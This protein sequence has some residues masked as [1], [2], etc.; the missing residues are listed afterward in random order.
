MIRL[1]A[2]AQ[3]SNEFIAGLGVGWFLMFLRRLVLRKRVNATPNVIRARII[4]TGGVR[5]PLLILSSFHF[6]REE[7]K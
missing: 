2:L 3:S 6:L 4:S 5:Y 7:S 1:P